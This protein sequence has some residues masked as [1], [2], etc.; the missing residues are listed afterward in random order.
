[1]QATYLHKQVNKIE[2]LASGKFIKLLQ[3]PIKYLRTIYF[4]NIVYPKLKQKQIVTTTIFN[5]TV[6]VALPASSDIYLCGGKTHFSEINLA[7]F[8]INTLQ[9]NS[10]FIDIGAHIGYYSILASQCITTGGIIS[11]EPT[12]DTYKLLQHNVATLPNV[13]AYNIALG[14][15]QSTLQFF[16][17]DNLHSEY[18]SFNITA[19]TTAPWFSTY[20]I[21][22]IACTTLDALVQEHNF[23][24]TVIKMDVEGFEDA[25]IAGGLSTFK[26]YKPILVMEYLFITNGNSPHKIAHQYLLELG[27]VCHTIQANGNTVITH[28]IDAYFIQNNITSDNVV[29]KHV[30]I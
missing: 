30:A 26:K 20:N 12:G 14:N 4:K 17:F 8:L 16:E 9:P 27:Y 22:P 21:T 15:T 23:I 11:I 2:Q 28:N 6:Q 24:P 1:M 25:V 18:N 29:Y 7:R 3:L 19:H 5:H 13:K 10:C